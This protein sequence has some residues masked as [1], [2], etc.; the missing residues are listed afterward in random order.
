VHF[1]V[2]FWD[3]DPLLF[4]YQLSVVHLVHLHL[5][6]GVGD[7]PHGRLLSQVEQVQSPE[8]PVLPQSQINAPSSLYF[9]GSE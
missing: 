3:Q 6:V 9:D 2:Q 7:P 8:V 1:G 5:A 4:H